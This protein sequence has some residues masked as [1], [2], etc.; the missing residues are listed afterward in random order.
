MKNLILFAVF[1]CIV[2]FASAQQYKVFKT[3]NEL[4][5]YLISKMIWNPDSTMDSRKKDF[6]ENYFGRAAPYIK[7][8][9]DTIV[10]TLEKPGKLVL[11]YKHPSA[12]RDDYL[13]PSMMKYYHLLI[14]IAMIETLDKPKLL[15]R[16]DKF[17][18]T[19]RY[20]DI[21]VAKVMINTN[22]WIFEK[23]NEST[24]ALKTYYDRLADRV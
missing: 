5:T 16:V 1:Y 9:I 19:F 15:K 24:L 17:A 10:Y 2:S 6:L 22:N 4:R 3:K 21:E 20:A 18:Q 7:N 13:S 12:H 14:A 23:A 8:I 11:L